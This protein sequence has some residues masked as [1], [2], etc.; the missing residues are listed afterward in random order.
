MLDLVEINDSTFAS[1]FHLCNG[2]DLSTYTKIHKILSEKDAKVISR[3]IL[4]GLAY[5]NSHK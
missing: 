2:P 3:S 5:L 1:V 4:E